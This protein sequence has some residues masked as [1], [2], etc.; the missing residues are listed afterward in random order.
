[1]V[2]N[3]DMNEL[4]RMVTNLYDQEKACIARVIRGITD[5]INENM[6]LKMELQTLKTEPRAIELLDRTK[7]GRSVKAFRC[8]LDQPIHSQ[9]GKH[10]RFR[11]GDLVGR[12]AIVRRDLGG[13][14]PTGELREWERAKDAAL[15]VLSEEPI[16][17]GRRLHYPFGDGEAPGE[18]A[19][20]GIMIVWP[21]CS[22]RSFSM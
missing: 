4:K 3:N 10:R 15:F 11:P 14:S 8:H 13:R 21:I 16:L 19:E 2:S 7:R 5:L 22:F 20:G 12:D 18:L 6:K 17:P 1:M 9:L